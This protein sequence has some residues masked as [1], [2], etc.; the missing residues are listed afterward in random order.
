MKS[1]LGEKL[2]PIL[3]EIESTLFEYEGDKPDFGPTAMRAAA[4]IFASVMLDKM[5]ELMEKEEI[6]DRDT[7]G[8]KMVEDLRKLVKTYTGIDSKEL[9]KENAA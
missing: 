4:F 3:E 1:T 5:W 7:M 2:T 8:F 9:Y 6:E